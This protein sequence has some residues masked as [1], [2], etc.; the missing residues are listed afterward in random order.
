MQSSKRRWGFRQDRSQFW[1]NGPIL[2]LYEQTLSSHSPPR[3][4]MI[5][6][7]HKLG[8]ASAAQV[9]PAFGWH[10]VCVATTDPPNS[11]VFCSVSPIHFGSDFFVSNVFRML[12]KLAIKIYDV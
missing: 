6:K 4:G 9:A 11:A 1:H 10:R 12:D 7:I 5:E 3:D 2:P 8:A